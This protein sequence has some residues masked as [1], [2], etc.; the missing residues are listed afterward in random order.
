MKPRNWPLC[1]GMTRSGKSV[2]MTDLLSQIAPYYDFMLLLEEG[3]SYG[4]FTE[5]NGSKP[6]IVHPDGTLCINYLDTNGAPLSNL[7]I[8]MASSL[9]CKLVGT[10]PTQKNR[11]CERHKSGATSSSFTTIISHN[12]ATIIGNSFQ[13]SRAHYR[14][15]ALQNVSADRR[16][17]RRSMDRVAPRP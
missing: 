9:V 10:T 17:F 7:H 5:A 13:S 6:I 2:F 11:S 3:L 12:G 14:C 8:D 15:A 16:D 4:I 1:L